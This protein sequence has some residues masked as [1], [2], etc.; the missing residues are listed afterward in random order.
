M[1]RI[2]DGR[3]GLRLGLRAVIPDLIGDPGSWLFTAF[4]K[5]KDAGF[6]ITNVE[7]GRR[8]NKNKDN[9]AGFPRARE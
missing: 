7:N 5:N 9:D 2:S 3:V 4:A 6:S 8:K 1:A